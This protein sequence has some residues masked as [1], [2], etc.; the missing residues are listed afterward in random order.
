MAGVRVTFLRHGQATHNVGALTAG[1]AAYRDPAHLDAALTPEGVRQTFMVRSGGR[2]G[3]EFDRVYCSPLRRCYQTLLGV[4]PRVEY[5]S[6]DVTLDDRLMEPQ[7]E[8][9]CNRRAERED[10]LRQV[11]TGWSLE[12]VGRTN[13]YDQWMEGGTVHDEGHA[14]FERRVREFTEQVLGRLPEGTRVLVVAHHDWIR[15]WFR[16]YEPERGGVSLG[17]CDWVTVSLKS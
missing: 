16:L 14:G 11:P 10:V 17:N 9:I 8:A 3:T 2:L 4:L 1:V 5:W 13:P 15:T 6:G 12:G 7:G